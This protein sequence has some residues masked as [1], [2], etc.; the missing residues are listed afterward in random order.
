[1]GGYAPG[2]EINLPL[3]FLAVWDIGIIFLF[4]LEKMI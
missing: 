2:C 1:M 3:F 4:S